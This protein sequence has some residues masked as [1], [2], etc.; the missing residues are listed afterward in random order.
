VS[1]W[2]AVPPYDGE[3]ELSWV[4]LRAVL[5]AYDEVGAGAADAATVHDAFDRVQAGSV[6]AVGAQYVVQHV[7]DGGC[8]RVHDLDHQAVGP[9]GAQVDV[10]VPRRR[11]LIHRSNISRPRSLSHRDPV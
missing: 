5:P 2:L 8:Q 4:G 7:L 9:R 1:H 3:C 10:V 11:A 6:G